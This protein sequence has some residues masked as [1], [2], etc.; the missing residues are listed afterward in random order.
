MK[1]QEQLGALYASHWDSLKK[2][3]IS[4]QQAGKKPS[5][6]FLLS[7]N[8]WVN[9]QPEE[10]WYVDADLRVM[11]FGQETNRW[12][13]NEDTGDFGIPPST[14][15]D[16]EVSMEAVMGIYEDFYATY[17]SESAFRYNGRKYGTFHH[18]V[19]HLAGLLTDCFHGKRVAYLWNNLVKV[20]KADG[21]GFCGENIFRAQL[22]VFPVIP[23]EIHI[24]RPDILIFL[25]GSY[26]DILERVFKEATFTALAPFQREEVA[27]I[28]LPGINI[29]AYR[30]YHPS[31]RIG[32]GQKEAFYQAITNDI[33]ITFLK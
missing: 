11:V 21:R 7:L 5:F 22:E 2:A 1:L 19:N 6:P 15:F 30:T 16:P 33:K 29:P 8:H 18:G 31:A 17:Y 9:G 28:T 3:M 10:N 13:G 27:R 14:A 24:L 20:G 23:E 26:D 25:T 4:S 12:T 32:K